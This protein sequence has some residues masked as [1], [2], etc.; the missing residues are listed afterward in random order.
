MSDPYS[1]HP[2]HTPAAAAAGVS[3]SPTAVPPTGAALVV[4]D[5]DG[6][7]ALDVPGGPCRTWPVAPACSCLPNNPAEWTADHQ[8]AVETA[9]EILWELTAGRYGLCRETVRPCQE[10]APQQC[11]PRG[12]RGVGGM[13]PVLDGG[14]WTNVSCGCSPSGCSCSSAA[15]LELPGPVHTDPPGTLLPQYPIQVWMN[16][17]QLTTGWRLYD[18]NRLIRT[19]GAP[20]PM[21]QQM[22]RPLVAP[23][24]EPAAA[25]GT[26]GIVYWRGTPVPAGGRRAVAQLACEFWKACHDKDGC[27]IP[28]RV[29]LVERE[30]VTYR[31]IDK[32]EFLKQGRVGITEID[33]WLAAVNPRSRHS[34]STVYSVD[35]PVWRVERTTG[36][37]GGPP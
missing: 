16:G 4:I 10:P 2:A 12:W 37:Y 14:R 26:F 28:S 18:G 21:C 17:A 6:T 15:E 31:M 3:A 32:Q 7:W 29:E 22:W 11:P 1:R 34:P 36:R 30:G 33:L 19:D 9:T 23:A 24:G 25:A 5:P 8:I 13:Y 20:W 27:R 35:G